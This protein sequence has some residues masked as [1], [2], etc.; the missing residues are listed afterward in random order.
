MNID[1]LA[2]SVRTDGHW[3]IDQMAPFDCIILCANEMGETG[4]QIIQDIYLANWGTTYSVDD[5]Y[6]ESTYTYLAEHVT[7]FI[8]RRFQSLDELLTLDRELNRM[9]ATSKSPDDAAA[10][11]LNEEMNRVYEDFGPEAASKYDQLF[12]KETRAIKGTGPVTPVSILNP[13]SDH[14]VP[15]LSTPGAIWAVPQAQQIFGSSPELPPLIY[16]S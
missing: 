2:N 7:P 14:G 4:V 16:L 11:V 3:W 6:V 5:M 12:H 9:T 10:E 8:N 1:A 15:G 13:I